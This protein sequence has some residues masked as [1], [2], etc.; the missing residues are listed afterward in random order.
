MRRTSLILSLS[1]LLG[2]PLLAD[3]TAGVEA[4]KAKNYSEA[5]TQFQQAIEELKVAGAEEDPKYAPY[6]LMLGNSLSKSG[7]LKDAVGPLK[8]ALKMKEEIGRASCRER[9]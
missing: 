8:T 5:I 6:Y 7:K 9:V 2:A 1:L 4:Y 3:Y